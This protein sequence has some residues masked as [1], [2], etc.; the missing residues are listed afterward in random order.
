[1][2]Y[3]Y[4]K[5]RVFKNKWF[6]R[7][8]RLEDVPDSVLLQAATEIVAGQVEADLGGCLFKKRLAREAWRLSCSYRIQKAKCGTYCLSLCV[9]QKCQGQ[10]FR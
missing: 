7:W 5:M 9:R 3:I 2:C 8:A 6:A 4:K 1:M 10:Y